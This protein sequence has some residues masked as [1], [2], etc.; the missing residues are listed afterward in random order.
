MSALHTA[1]P[2][3]ALHGEPASNSEQLGGELGSQNSG[4]I[5]RLQV[6]RLTRRHVAAAAAILAPFAFGEV[7]R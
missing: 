7:S 5:E 4:H 3:T 1:K 6:L 2:A